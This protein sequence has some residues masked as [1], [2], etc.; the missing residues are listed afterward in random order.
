MEGPVRALVVDDEDG[1]RFFLKETLRRVGF[2]VEESGN[3]EEALERLRE[4]SYDL[5]MLD[6]HLGGRVDG[7][8]VLE[9]AK[10]RWPETAVIILTAH[11]SLESTLT[12]IQEGVDGYLL[13]PVEAE[14][15]RQAVREALARRH[16]CAS[17][18]KAAEETLLSVGTLTLDLE[19]HLVVLEGQ[20]LDLTPS[21]FRLLAHL[22][23]ASPKVV[24]AKEMVEVVQGYRPDSEWEARQ[25]IKWYVHRLRRKVEQDPSQPRHI[26]N[27]RGVGYR[28]QP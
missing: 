21:E 7:H 4:N 11:A 17:P 13:K 26:L 22:M 9:A 1:I 19:K 10:W 23:R 16:R 24:P 15:V 18:L 20:P 2:D 25:I 5:V 8:R 6:L 3:G 27:V 28:L 14:G 12:A